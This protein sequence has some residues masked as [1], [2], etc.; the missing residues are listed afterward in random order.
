EPN[1]V[2]E[3]AEFLSF[4][5]SYLDGR[6]ITKG[7]PLTVK[8][9]GQV[10]YCHVNSLICDTT[11]LPCE[12]TVPE[13]AS[14]VEP[15]AS[16]YL[17]TGGNQTPQR[18]TVAELR[19]STQGG[20]S[21]IVDGNVLSTPTQDPSVIDLDIAS[22]TISPTT[23]TPKMC[24]RDT[25]PNLMTPIST[26]G[27]SGDSNTL[28]S[29]VFAKVSSKFTTVS[30]QLAAEIR[31]NVDQNKPH[32]SLA[33]VGGMRLQVEELKTRIL[34]ALQPKCINRCI[35]LHGPPG[36]GKSL[37]VKALTLDLDMATTY[38]T[39][40]DIWS[41]LFGEAESN[42]CKVFKSAQNKAPSIVV[43]DDIDVMC[44]K[45]SQVQ[46]GQQEQRIVGTLLTLL[47]SLASVQNPHQIVVVIGITNNRDN[48]DPAL[49]RAG[50][51]GCEVEVGVPTAAQRREIL[52]VLLNK[53]AH[54]L[55]AE[56]IEAAA[57]NAHGYVGADLCALINEAYMHSLSSE[58]A[59]VQSETVK[60]AL[61]DLVH[62][63]LRVKPSALREIQL[64]VPQVKWTDIG[65]MSEVKMRLRE[66]V[67]LPQTNP[68]VFARLGIQP[69]K[70]LLMYGPPGCSKTMVA[71]ALA[72]ECSLNFLAV[73]G[74]ELFNKYVGESEKAVRE[75]FRKA[76]QAA[77]SIIFFDEIDAI[78]VNRASSESTSGVQNRVLTQLLTEM[79][80]M[81][82]LKDVFI[83]AATNRPDLI[84][85][86]LMRPGRFDNLVYVPLPD[87]ETRTQILQKKL[88]KMSVA[89][90][91]SLELLVQATQDYSGAEIVQVCQEAA[92]YALREDIHTEKVLARHFDA[93]LGKVQPQTDPHLM[94]IYSQF[95]Q[96][97]S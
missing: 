45:R 26:R 22:L 7:T 12:R 52:E 56:D 44:P 72:T 84:D 17:Q 30:L 25:F 50:R 51:F 32:V 81:Q 85:P 53:V 64:E 14:S 16:E 39:G 31:G 48:I 60:L 94:E 65:G 82:F 93:A 28:S 29:Q 35:L 54:N 66:A 43:I 34:R 80:G 57:R 8:Y 87:A 69:P 15:Q 10:C 88:N 24:P 89:H 92:F 6:Y 74:P 37:L 83:I 20:S 77:P 47:D 68:E 42:L 61:K 1:D 18:R 62:A 91:V 67:D 70:G 49:R 97:S 9:F 75:V 58:A 40:T 27:Q 78:A 21:P 90:D 4:M 79:D 38:M 73:K 13:P 41:K 59:S 55:T 33:D 96:S 95:S 3:K 19:E 5:T 86:A 36:T 11:S 2:F 76:R 46:A 23:S 71:R 63:G